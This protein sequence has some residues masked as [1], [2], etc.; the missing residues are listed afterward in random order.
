MENKESK[1]PEDWFQ[2]AEKDLKRAEIMLGVKDLVAAGV[3]L[4]Q[5]IEKY[6]KGYLLSKDWELEKTHN[7]IKLLNYAVKYDISFDDFRELC[8][9]TTTYYSIE[10]YPF[11]LKLDITEEEITD[12]F[13]KTKELKEK[14][15]KKWKEKKDEK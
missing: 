12:G 8:Q 14:I 4:Q 1:L 15:L 2:I 5:S 11:F 3:F 7:L 13:T 6:L 10:R 9:R